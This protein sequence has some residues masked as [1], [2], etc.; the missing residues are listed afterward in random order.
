M[1]LNDLIERFNKIDQYFKDKFPEETHEVR[2]LARL[3]KI[4]EELGELSNATLSELGFQR[5]EKLDA[6]RPTDVEEEWADLF[7]TV[8]LYG[9]Y[10][11]ID[12]PRVIDTKLDQIL[13]RYKLK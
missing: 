13:T 1:T 8:I 12:M 4:S 2:V 9:I 11:K 6:H 3:A 5:Q 10:M 7:N